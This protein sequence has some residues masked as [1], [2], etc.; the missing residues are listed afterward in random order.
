MKCVPLERGH[1][2]KIIKLQKSDR[3]KRIRGPPKVTLDEARRPAHRP[4]VTEKLRTS[5]IQ[6]GKLRNKYKS[7]GQV[8]KT[9][10]WGIAARRSRQPG[11][12]RRQHTSQKVVKV[13]KK[14]RISYKVTKKLRK[15]DP[16]N[17]SSGASPQTTH[18]LPSFFVFVS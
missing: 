5:Y 15:R 1:F 11:G 10:P 9:D 17:G 18:S 14:L 2:K 6:Y 7:Y 3:T 12:T 16:D 8:T 13:T 4:G